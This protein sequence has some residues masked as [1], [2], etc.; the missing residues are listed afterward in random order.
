MSL[1][2]ETKRVR[3]QLIKP[4]RL[5]SNATIRESFGCLIRVPK[6]LKG[7]LLLDMRFLVPPAPGLALDPM[8][9][10]EPPQ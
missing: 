8:L 6:V 2:T 5:S 3:E 7:R 9:F 4:K 10:E 1:Q